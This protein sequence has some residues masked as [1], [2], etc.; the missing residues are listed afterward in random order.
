MEFCAEQNK[1]IV[2]VARGMQDMRKSGML[3][4]THKSKPPIS[5]RT[6]SVAAWFQLHSGSSFSS[7]VLSLAFPMKLMKR[8]GKNFLQDPTRTFDDDFSTTSSNVTS[9]FD[10]DSS[11]LNA[12]GHSSSTSWGS[13]SKNKSVRFA[14][15]LNVEY[16]NETV[17]LCE[18]KDLWYQVPD[19]Q[20][21]RSLAYDTAQQIIATE[22]R[23]RAPHSYQRVMERTYAACCKYGNERGNYFSQDVAP[24]NS[25]AGLDANSLMQVPS[26]E[27]K[28]SGVFFHC[29]LP[30]DEFVHLQRW[31]E[32]GS[33]RIGLE[34]HS[35]QCISSTKSSR[36]DSITETILLLRQQQA[37][38]K[39]NG[40]IRAADD[41]N[42]KA[43]FIRRTSE[44][45]SRSS[46]LFSLVLAQGLAAAVVKENYAIEN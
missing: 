14:T 1:V 38:D 39:I 4:K 41:E 44:R 30:P 19:Y 15:H 22:K 24:L 42:A 17:A 29:V 26:D 8:N 3:G 46:C 12:S 45:L 11:S 6:N 2:I 33:S 35:I 18:M 9:A 16:T 23:N 40:K 28:E 43:E 25:N 37:R 36:R 13:V 10:D 32:V 20:S 31:L 21:F 34:K 5:R 7:M 27:D